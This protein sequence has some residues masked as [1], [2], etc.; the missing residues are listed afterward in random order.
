MRIENKITKKWPMIIH[1]NGPSKETQIWKKVMEVYDRG[2]KRQQNPNDKLTVLTWSVEGE[3]FLLKRVMEDMGC[4]EYLNTI[5]LDK[6]RNGSI[7]WL[8]KI[9]KTLEFIKLIDTPYV[10]GLD[11]LDVIPSTDVD[12]VL[13]DDIVKCFEGYGA[14]IVYNAEKANWPSTDGHGTILSKPHPLINVLQEVELHDEKIYKDF[15]KSDWKHL[16]SG[17]W[18]GK[19]D[20]LIEFYTEV[21]ELINSVKNSGKPNVKRMNEEIFFGGDQGFI[22]LVASRWF[23]KVVLDYRCELFQTLVYTETEELGVWE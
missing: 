15:L 21:V 12:S 2:P 13:W 19:T 10:M 14:D 22:R 5:Y 8:D 23:P 7:N 18:I 16:N 9:T 20:V 1:G 3:E 6:D 17:G 11:A 4:G